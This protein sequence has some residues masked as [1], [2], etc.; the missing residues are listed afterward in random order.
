MCYYTPLV[1]VEILY[2]SDLEYKH[3]LDS[4]M[5]TYQNG[6][7]GVSFV[8][9]LIRLLSWVRVSCC[10]SPFHSFAGNPSGDAPADQKTREC[11]LRILWTSHPVFNRLLLDASLTCFVPDYFLNE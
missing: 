1:F 10:S 8:R 4:G 2:Q 7:S 3:H 6:R 5:D 11:E 9:H